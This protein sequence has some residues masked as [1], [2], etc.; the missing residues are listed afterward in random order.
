MTRPTLGTKVPEGHG[1]SQALFD[2]RAATVHDHQSISLT[3]PDAA[4]YS[5]TAQTLSACVDSFPGFDQGEGFPGPAVV[6]GGRPDG[7]YMGGVHRVC[8]GARWRQLADPRL[9]L[10]EPLRVLVDRGHL[11]TYGPTA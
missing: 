8:R 3:C 4:V 1:G 5:G 11:A 7:G 6:D 10:R 9:R 2:V